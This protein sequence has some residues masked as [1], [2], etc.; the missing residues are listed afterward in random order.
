MG[1]APGLRCG[2][3]PCRVIV[4]SIIVCFVF[5]APYGDVRALRI[6]VEVLALSGDVLLI[7]GRNRAPSGRSV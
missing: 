4:A 1:L 6:V 5:D 3:S 7:A 2:T